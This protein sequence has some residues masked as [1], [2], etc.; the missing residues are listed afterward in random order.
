MPA[1]T[2]LAPPPPPSPPLP[3]P[4]PPPPVVVKVVGVVPIGTVAMGF[5]VEDG[6]SGPCCSE[7]STGPLVLQHKN[8][9]SEEMMKSGW[10]KELGGICVC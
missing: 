3:P 2:A 9:A 4:P 8:A 5:V 10:G 6:A 1:T 7:E